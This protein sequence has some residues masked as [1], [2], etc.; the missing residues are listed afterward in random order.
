MTVVAGAY[1]WWLELAFQISQGKEKGTRWKKSAHI[2]AWTKVSVGIT[3]LMPEEQVRPSKYSKLTAHKPLA[4]SKW[5]WKKNGFVWVH[6]YAFQQK[7]NNSNSNVLQGRMTA[8]KGVEIKN[9][10]KLTCNYAGRQQKKRLGCLRCHWL[11]AQPLRF[12]TDKVNL[13][14]LEHNF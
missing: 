4:A 6:T 13:V 9:C 14:M 12:Y 10:N 2:H 1:R 5:S 11:P 3:W 7:R 8:G